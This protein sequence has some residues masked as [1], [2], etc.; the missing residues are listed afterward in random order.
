MFDWVGLCGGGWYYD[1]I[2]DVWVESERLYFGI[3][4][5]GSVLGIMWLVKFWWVWFVFWNGVFG[6]V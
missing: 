5:G 2:D 6:E 3:L 1:I 4:C